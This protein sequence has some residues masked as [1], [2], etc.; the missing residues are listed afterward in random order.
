MR[1]V[2]TESHCGVREMRTDLCWKCL[3]LTVPQTLEHLHALNKLAE[4]WDPRANSLLIFYHT[5]PTL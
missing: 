1:P 2:H 3:G 4:G 5:W